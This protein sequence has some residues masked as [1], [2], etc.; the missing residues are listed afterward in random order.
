MFAPP[1][2][3]TVFPSHPLV[4]A[5]T[6]GDPGTSSSSLFLRTGL[7]EPIAAWVSF[8]VCAWKAPP[9]PGSDQHV[10]LHSFAQSHSPDLSFTSLC[11][12]QGGLD[13]RQAEEAPRFLGWV[14]SF[15]LR[16]SQGYGAPWWPKLE[17]PLPH[18]GTARPGPWGWGSG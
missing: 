12:Q 4:R 15:C 7:L 14:G 9:G 6:L 13:T 11:P 1:P 10:L 18:R 16:E 17:A 5:L 2:P 3:P 8:C